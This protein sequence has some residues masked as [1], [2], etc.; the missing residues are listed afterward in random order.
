[1][2][3]ATYSD[4]ALRL[5]MYTAVKHPAYVTI[6]EVSEAYGISK[7]HL[8]KVTHELALAGYLD[9]LRGR[10]GGLRLAR[11]AKEINVGQVVRL[12]EKGSALVECFDPATNTCVI[13]PA[14]KLKH[15]LNDALE[16]FFRT[17]EQTTLADLIKSK[18]SLSALYLTEA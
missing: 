16:A 18:R 9:T 17:L 4:F 13:T 7:N 3:I 12:T 5:L 2:R 8:M 1:M 14:C 10:N 15:V 6:T 11:P